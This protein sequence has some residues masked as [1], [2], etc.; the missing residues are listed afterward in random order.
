MADFNKS[1]IKAFSILESFA[2]AS[3]NKLTLLELSEITKIPLSTVFRMVS[4]LCSLGYLYREELTK[5]YHLGWKV[6]QIAESMERSTEL[7]LKEVAYP[8]VTE[9]SEKHNENT[10]IYTQIDKKRICIMRVDGTQEVRNIVSVGYIADIHL[11]SPGKVLLAFLPENRWK[12]YVSDADSSFF[13]L[14]REVREVGFATSDGERT[15][16]VSSI[17]A[18]VFDANNNIIAALTLSGPVF[19]FKENKYEEKIKNVKKYA[20]LI[21]NEIIKKSK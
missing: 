10:S 7:L 6:A 16:G 17:S 8:F 21:T 13:Q 20:R 19:R 11:G 3:K 4:T 15:V 5:A 2:I 14:L 1:T 12:Y 18:P 9:L